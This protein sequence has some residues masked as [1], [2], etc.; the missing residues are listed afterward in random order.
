[1]HLTHERLERAERWFERW[2]DWAVLVGRVTPIAR[3]F[4]S[5]PAGVFG[6]P[7][8]R[9]NVLTLIGNTAWCAVIAGI[10]YGLGSSYESFNHGFKYVE[11]AVVLL[12]VA[13]VG[14]LVLRRRRATVSR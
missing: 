4:I 13:A 11:Y 12:I 14:Y 6:M 7:F 3:S 2:N 5:I 8:K 1:V 9:Y 10:G